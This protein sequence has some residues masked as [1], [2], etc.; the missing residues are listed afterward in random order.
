MAVTPAGHLSSTSQDYLNILDITNDLV[1]LQDGSTAMVLQV[2]A[3]N[4]GL[5]SEP[6]QD[7]IIY[8]Y[9]SLI[10]SL[11]FS[12]QILIKSKPKDVSNYLHY[13]DEQLEGAPSELRRQQIAA[14]RQFV[15]N[16]ITERNV[17]DKTFYV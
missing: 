16:L 13:V 10:N 1:V 12:L 7:A 17:L 4:F 11:S 8:A 6:E 3:I 14:Y 9:A 5:L 2:S 15:A